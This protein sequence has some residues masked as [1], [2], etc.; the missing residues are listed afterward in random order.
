[1]KGHEKLTKAELD[2]VI[3]EQVKVIDEKD[4]IIRLLRED[5]ERLY[6]LHM[7]YAIPVGEDIGKSIII[8]NQHEALL[9]Q[10]DEQEAEK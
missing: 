5:G 7:K 6:A 2:F 1:M 3:T 9:K 8:F 10:L 4:N